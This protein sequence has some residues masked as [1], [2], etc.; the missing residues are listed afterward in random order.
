MVTARPRAGGIGIHPVQAVL[1][2]SGLPLFLGALLS[3]WA[4]SITHEVQWINFAA[5][6]II[7]ALVFAGSALVW[8]LIDLLRAHL[9]KGRIRIY[10][11]IAML[12]VFVIGLFD[13]FI[14]ARDAWAAMPAGL[15]LSLLATLL[16]LLSVALGFSA[17]RAGDRR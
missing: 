17:L 11:T 1:L 7:G 6:L 8:A 9:R 16:A 13:A 15:I 14:H 10:Y 12:S 3:D 4:Y 2:A 5:W